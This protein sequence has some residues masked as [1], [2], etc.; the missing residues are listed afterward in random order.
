MKRDIQTKLTTESVENIPVGGLLRIVKDEYTCGCI[1]QRTEDRFITSKEDG[2]ADVV[3]VEDCSSCRQKHKANSYSFNRIG[4][5]C[6]I[7]YGTQVFA[8]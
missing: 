5:T 6:W 1:F 3:V 4:F 7:P 2:H 8:L